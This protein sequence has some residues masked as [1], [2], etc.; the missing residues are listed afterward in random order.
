MPEDIFVEN[1]KNMINQYSSREKQYS[2]VKKISVFREMQ[3]RGYIRHCSLIYNENEFTITLSREIKKDSC[4]MCGAPIDG[5]LKD[6]ANCKYC[7][8]VID[9]ALIKK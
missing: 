2:I 4:P 1:L 7:G 3:K 6:N 8:Y 5:T 9:D